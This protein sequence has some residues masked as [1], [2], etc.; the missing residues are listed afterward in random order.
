M[1]D[2]WGPWPSLST[3]SHRAGGL[4]WTVLGW[5]TGGFL[6]VTHAWRVM[7]SGTIGVHLLV[8]ACAGLQLLW[9]RCGATLAPCAMAK[10]QPTQN[11]RGGWA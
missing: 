1:E 6:A 8:S 10:L 2:S 5:G 11:R 7:G 9:Q 3:P 4:S